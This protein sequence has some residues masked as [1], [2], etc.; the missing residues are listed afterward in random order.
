MRTARRR[1]TG[2]RNHYAGEAAECIVARHYAD[3]GCPVRSQRWRGQA[4]EIDLVAE[5]NGGVIFVEVK[6]SK[7]HARAAERLGHAQIERLYAAGAEYLAGLPGG[8]ATEA[9]FDV[10]LVD[11]TGRVEVVENAIVM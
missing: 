5:A 3:A 8:Q 1:R 7:S 4:G 9:R 11:G 10:A 2:S 6:A